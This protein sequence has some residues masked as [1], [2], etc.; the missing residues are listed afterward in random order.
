MTGT[1]Y[2]VGTGPGD[3]ELLTIKALKIIKQSDIIAI[4]SEDE[5]SC[6]S[7]RTVKGIY[8]E[9]EDKRLLKLPFPMTKDAAAL[10][11]QHEENAAKVQTFLDKGQTVAFLTIGDPSIYS[12]YGYLHRILT[13]RGY[14]ARIISGIPS[15]CAAAASLGEIL[16]EGS[17]TL[18]ILPASYDLKAALRS[19]GTKVLMKPKRRFSSVLRALKESGRSASMVENCGLGEEHIFRKLEDFPQDSGYFSIILSRLPDSPLPD[20]PH[21]GGN[22][23]SMRTEHTD[24]HIGGDY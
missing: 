11:R 16:C 5:K 7:F 8:P 18:E 23:D 20:S 24:K 12:T 17:E 10:R 13:K 3:P 6:L 4:P 9:I 2:G 14:E 1:L 15:F 21:C 22:P 19:S